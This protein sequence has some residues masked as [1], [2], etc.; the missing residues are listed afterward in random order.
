VI[1]SSVMGPQPLSRVFQMWTSTKSP[2]Q[3]PKEPGKSIVFPEVLSFSLREVTCERERKNLDC[4]SYFRAESVGALILRPYHKG[5][6]NL[7]GRRS[8]AG[9]TMIGNPKNFKSKIAQLAVTQNHMYTETP[10]PGTAP[11]TP[12]SSQKG[13]LA[14]SGCEMTETGPELPRKGSLRPALPARKNPIPRPE[15]LG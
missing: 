11:L 5:N 3:T 6:L 12:V 7:T 13:G 4:R 2:E 9:Y 8:K 14:P 10:A 1:A 15:R